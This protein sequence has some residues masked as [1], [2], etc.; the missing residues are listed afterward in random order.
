MVQWRIV[1][2]RLRPT[3]EIARIPQARMADVEQHSH[4]MVVYLSACQHLALM[5]LLKGKFALPH[6]L[7]IR[8]LCPTTA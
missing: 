4:Q 1:M 6:A 5:H 2:I 8:R 7:P 3:H